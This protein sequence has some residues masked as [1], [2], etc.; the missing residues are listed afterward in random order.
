MPGRPALNGRKGSGWPEPPGRG[1]SVTLE[2]DGP[3]RLASASLKPGVARHWLKQSGR[4]GSG[5]TETLTPRNGEGR[6]RTVHDPAGYRRPQHPPLEQAGPGWPGGRLS[7]VLRGRLLRSPAR[8]AHQRP[9]AAVS[10][11]SSG[12]LPVVPPQPDPANRTFLL[13]IQRTFSRVGGLRAAC[14]A[15]SGQ[16]MVYLWV[17]LVRRGP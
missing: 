1:T 11:A 17:P 8:A 6:V 12:G 16:V 5:S 2:C 9:I 13:G 7:R 3:D 4:F 10:A 14:L 15:A